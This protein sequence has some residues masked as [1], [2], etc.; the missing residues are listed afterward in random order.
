MAKKKN[1]K[2]KKKTGVKKT[3]KKTQKKIVANKSAKTKKKD[4]AT[5]IEKDIGKAVEKI[6]GPT[7]KE[8]IQE[9]QKKISYLYISIIFIILFIGIFAFSV[10]RTPGVQLGD[11]I[12]LKYHGTYENGTLFD[13]GTIEFTVGN[14]EIIRGL[15][16]NVKGLKEGEE[17][18]KHAYGEW[19]TENL[20][21]INA[22]YTINRWFDLTIDEAEERVS[23]D[24][25]IGNT[26]TIKDNMWMSK[27]TDLNR[28]FEEVRF[29]HVPIVNS[30]YYNPLITWWPVRVLEIGDTKITLRHEPNIGSIIR[31]RN[32]NGAIIEGKVINADEESIV[33]D[34][35][36]RMAGKTLIFDVTVEEIY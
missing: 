34:F 31:K 18:R 26:V 14:G 28:D 13:E 22:T 2:K 35:N 24:L 19:S 20:E 32:E 29:E 12:R 16:Y 23:G 25:K 4:I 8:K 27:I 5:K 33:I 21:V 1:V 30:T 15:D 11:K 10:M 9:K 3:A 17:K 6:A 7:L 36:N